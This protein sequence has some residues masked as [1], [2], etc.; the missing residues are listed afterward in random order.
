MYHVTRLDDDT[1]VVVE[2]A[3]GREICV[4]CNYGKARHAKERAARVAHCLEGVAALE[5]QAQRCR[6]YL[7]RVRT[8]GQRR[9][10]LSV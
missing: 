5:Q 4:C 6:E 1:Y 7:E 3:T 9:G 8:D 2:Q 10:V